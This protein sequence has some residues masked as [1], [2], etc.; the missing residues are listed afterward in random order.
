MHEPA[1]EQR[2]SRAGQ[3]RLA[4]AVPEPDTGAA[5]GNGF[6]GPPSPSLARHEGP[7]DRRWHRAEQCTVAG[8]LGDLAV[9]R[10]WPPAGQQRGTQLCHSSRCI[11]PRA[12]AHLAVLFT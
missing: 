5:L 12:L 7:L 4:P 3:G 11:L 1:D 6:T 2:C 8:V 10:S 9:G